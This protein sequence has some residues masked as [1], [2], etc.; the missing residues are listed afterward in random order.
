MEAFF[1]ERDTSVLRCYISCFDYRSRI[2]SVF[3]C[4]RDLLTNKSS[5]M[6]L[7]IAASQRSVEARSPGL[8]NAGMLLAQIV[9]SEFHVF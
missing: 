3:D 9:D 6:I 8:R 2:H 4:Q 5:E 7:N 1:L